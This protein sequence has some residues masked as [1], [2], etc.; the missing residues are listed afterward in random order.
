M[1]WAL[2]AMMS[3]AM[4]SALVDGLIAGNECNGMWRLDGYRDGGVIGID[5]LES[6]IGT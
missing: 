6:L 4:R 5:S 1:A 2:G 3:W